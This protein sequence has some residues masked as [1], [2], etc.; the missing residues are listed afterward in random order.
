MRGF[1]FMDRDLTGDDRS[2][3]HEEA[4]IKMYYE[5]ASCET[6]AQQFNCSSQAVGKRLRA[7]GINTRSHAG[8]YTDE[9][10]AELRDRIQHL[11][12]QGMTMAGIA[13]S[14][15]LSDTSVSS[16]LQAIRKAKTSQYWD[17]PQSVN[18]YKL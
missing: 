9:Q 4:I 3:I 12:D 15:G 6:I 17:F 10:L 5:G 14:V 2:L 13:N 8:R 1:L 11:R 7:A 18:P 16:H